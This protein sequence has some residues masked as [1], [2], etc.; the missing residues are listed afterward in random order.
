MDVMC[1]DDGWT[2]GNI[3]SLPTK[4]PEFG[5]TYKVID[6]Q[7]CDNGVWYYRLAGFPY[8]WEAGAFVPVSTIDETKFERNYKKELV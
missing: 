3:P 8:F 5:E 2:N 7:Q 6:C 4:C 1:I